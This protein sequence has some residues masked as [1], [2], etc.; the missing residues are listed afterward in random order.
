MREQAKTG[1]WPSGALSEPRSVAVLADPRRQMFNLL[2][3]VGVAAHLLFDGSYIIQGLAQSN[4][5]KL[6]FLAMFLLLALRD[7]GQLRGL[8][9]IVLVGYAVLTL[10]SVLVAP[11]SGNLTSSLWGSLKYFY[12]TFLTFWV[13]AKIFE[14]RLLRL[15]AVVNT[16]V[17][18][19]VVFAVTANFVNIS[20]QVFHLTLPAIEI[21]LPRLGYDTK[22]LILGFEF[23]ESYPRLQSI[24]SEANKFAQFLLV[25]FFLLL[26]MRRTPLSRLFL[27]IVASAF[28]FT[29]SFASHAGLFVG[30][31]LWFS[32]RQPSR[33]RRFA[34]MGAGG[35]LLSL[36]FIYLIQSLWATYEAEPG[37]NV[38]YRTVAGKGPSWRQSWDQIILGVQ[39]ASENPLG[40]GMIDRPDTGVFDYGEKNTANALG[41]TLVRFG[42]LGIIVYL[43]IWAVVL[44]AL[45]HYAAAVRAGNAHPMGLAVGV[46]Y[47]AVMVAATNYG[48]YDQRIALVSLA[49]FLAYTYRQRAIRQAS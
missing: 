39:S 20:V 1:D 33:L 16:W 9:L 7:G 36:L 11:G 12:R 38:Y 25:P 45:V 10:E 28:V 31:F 4:L 46:A 26:A 5:I 49:L 17:T 43:V 40:I 24:F 3:V 8:A 27:V 2:V 35:L 47:F 13:F 22:P 19:A 14:S 37:D 15:D 30:L 6:S 29:F 41:Q 34:L 44:R 21:P 48:P 23:F 32:L 18:M 42:V